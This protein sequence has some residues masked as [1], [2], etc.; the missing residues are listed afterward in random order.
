MINVSNPQARA[1]LSIWSQVHFSELLGSTTLINRSHG[2]SVTLDG[3][4][5]F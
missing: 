2:Y 3:M 1:E 4:D 5:F